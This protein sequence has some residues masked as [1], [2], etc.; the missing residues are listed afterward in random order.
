MANHQEIQE[1]VTI[2]KA[3][4]PA[5]KPEVAMILGSGL[6]L[7]AHAVTNQTVLPYHQIPGFPTP[8]VVGHAG[9][10]I[11]GN[12]GEKSVI[13][14]QGRFHYYEGHSMD[15]LAFPISV[16][17]QLGVKKL[18]VTASTAGVNPNFQPGDIILIH[19]HINLSFN[20][21]LIGKPANKATPNYPAL[22][23]YYSA[24]IREIA[25]KQ[26]KRLNLDLKTGVYLF[27]PGPSFE[28]PAEIRMMRM[29]GADV[30]GMSTVPEV[31]AAARLDMNIM[32]M[33]Y[34][35]NMGSGMVAGKI[36]HEKTLAVLDAIKD[37]LISLLTAIISD[38]AF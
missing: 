6:G 27:T 25:Q 14:M 15:R 35:A 38:P 7:I 1:A 33:T 22:S 8:K 16:L 9:K 20:N 30:V 12:M 3:Q 26:A 24:E 4:N 13:L 19:D 29:L 34:V 21:P 10:L 31:L 36:E 28:T 17:H 18:I 23:P 32:A 5:F 37:D 11:I 2:I